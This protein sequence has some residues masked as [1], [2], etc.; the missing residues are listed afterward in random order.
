MASENNWKYGQLVKN[1]I[2]HFWGGG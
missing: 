2:R 1:Q